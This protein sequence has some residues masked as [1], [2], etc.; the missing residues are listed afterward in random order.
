M[1]KHHS[2]REAAATALH[3]R[4]PKPSL[5]GAR[6][7]GNP[8]GIGF[9]VQTNIQNIRNQKIEPGSLSSLRNCSAT[10]DDD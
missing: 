3:Y 9:T 4:R 5:R 8:G 2:K 1:P 6:R 7:R 10:R